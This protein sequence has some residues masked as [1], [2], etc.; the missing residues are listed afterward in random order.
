MCDLICDKYDWQQSLQ[1]PASPQL[2][3]IL[4]AVDSQMT[5]QKERTT[6][7]PIGETHGKPD[8]V[9][10][11]N[12][13]C[14]CMDCLMQ[15][16]MAVESCG[17]AIPCDSDD[18]MYDCNAG[19]GEGGCGHYQIF[20][21]YITDARCMC[22]GIACPGGG[23]LNCCPGGEACC[24]IPEDAHD[25]LCNECTTEACCQ[26]KKALAELIMDCWFR[27]YSRNQ[28]SGNCGKDKCDGHGATEMDGHNCLTCSDIAK[29]HK[30]GRCGHRCCENNNECCC[31]PPTCPDNPAEGGDACGRATQYWDRVKSAMC[32]IPG[33]SNCSDC[34]P[35]P[36]T[37]CNKDGDCAMHGKNCCNEGYC[38]ECIQFEKSIRRSDKERQDFWEDYINKN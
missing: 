15:A 12:R 6:N 25:T 30:E 38:V 32:S 1:P 23:F 33:C 18:P 34:E 5:A 13:C 10:G 28:G 20:A 4:N 7:K 24:G 31:N 19:D 35:Y 22:P 17:G 16:I 27:R 11:I 37:P 21:D 29:M 14:D 26:E 8:D 3:K 36:H 9:D 2:K